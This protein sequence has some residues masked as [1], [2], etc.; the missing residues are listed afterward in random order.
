[1]GSPPGRPRGGGASRVGSRSWMC[2]G[3]RRRLGVRS[4]LLGS[5]TRSAVWLGVDVDHCAQRGGEDVGEIAMRRARTHPRAARGCVRVLAQRISSRCCCS[6]VDPIRTPSWVQLRCTE[7][8][9]IVIA[10]HRSGPAR[11]WGARPPG[12][13]TPSE[14]SR[15]RPPAVAGL[16]AHSELGAAVAAVDGDDA[17][18]WSGPGAARDRA[19]GSRP[20]RAGCG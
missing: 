17:P 11:A 14:G 1:M 2:H 19:P 13:A 3:F 20:A 12:F 7:V 10:A 4:L 16:G 9:V 5:S 18:A 6:L 8:V 15:H